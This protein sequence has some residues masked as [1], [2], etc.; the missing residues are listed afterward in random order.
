MSAPEKPAVPRARTW[1][2]TS[3]DSGIFLVW[4][5]RIPSRPFTSGRLTTMRRSKR[6]GRSSA[7]SS[8]PGRVEAAGPRQRGVE[9]VGAFGGGAQDAA[10]FRLEAVLLDE[11][12]VQGLLA[13]VVPAP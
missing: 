2:F 1:M 4:T 5:A 12:R 6:P 3:S 10:F 7:G 11:Q 9:H 13:L 8:T